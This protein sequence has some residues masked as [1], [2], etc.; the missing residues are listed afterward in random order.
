MKTIRAVI[1]KY[2]VGIFQEIGKN[3]C[4]KIELI[5]DNSIAISFA[6]GTRE[7]YCGLPFILTQVEE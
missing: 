4:T 3:G 6:S 5:S 1:D 2:G 7:V